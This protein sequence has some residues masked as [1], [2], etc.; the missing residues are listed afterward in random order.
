VPGKKALLKTCAAHNVGI[1]A[2]KPYAGG[3]LL[4]KER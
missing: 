3:K 4:S 1:V 2:M